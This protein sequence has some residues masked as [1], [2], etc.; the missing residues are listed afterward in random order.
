MVRGVVL[1][2]CAQG[3][4]MNFLELGRKCTDLA[5]TDFWGFAATGVF[6]LQH[7][8]HS[9]GLYIQREGMFLRQSI[10]LIM[11]PHHESL[12]SGGVIT[13]AF[14]SQASMATS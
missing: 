8:H 13:K 7:Q 10:R 6:A 14:I 9:D 5:M 2:R 3:A 4:M 11:L 12:S 1:M